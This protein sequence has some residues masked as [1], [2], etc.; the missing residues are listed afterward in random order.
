MG[1][2]LTT[3]V[4]PG[5]IL[6]S[7]VPHLVKGDPSLTFQGSQQ[8]EFKVLLEDDKHNLRI[9]RGRLDKPGKI[10]DLGYELLMTATLGINS[11]ICESTCYQLSTVFKTLTWHSVIIRMGFVGIIIAIIPRELVVW[12]PNSQ[13][14]NRVLV[15]AHL[16][17]AEYFFCWHYCWR[18]SR[19]RGVYNI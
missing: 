8:F 5:M 11:R 14:T 16:E 3:Y 15:T 9:R 12:S 2:I 4:R 17:F 19:E 6:L 13:Q 18:V 1:V 10:T 7:Y